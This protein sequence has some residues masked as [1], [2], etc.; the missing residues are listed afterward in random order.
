MFGLSMTEMVFLG[1]LALIVIG[2]KQLPELARNLGRFMSELKRATDGFTTELKNQAR[3]DFNL[4]A[5]RL[6]DREVVPP[7]EEMPP[8]EASHGP[9]SV[10]RPV[11]QMSFPIDEKPEKPS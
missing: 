4:E 2:P 7:H 8:S 10:V 6:K 9:E 1:V 3:V 5:H 11:E